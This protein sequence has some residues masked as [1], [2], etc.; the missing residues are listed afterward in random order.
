VITL[1]HRKEIIKEVNFNINELS[2]YEN[3]REGTIRLLDQTLSLGSAS[4]STY[5]NAFQRMNEMRYICN[6]GAKHCNQNMR[7]TKTEQ[8]QDEA[9]TNEHELDHLLDNS[10]E[11]CLICGTDI[12]EEQ[13]S[14]GDGSSATTLENDQLRL[15]T[16]CAQQRIRMS[17]PQLPASESEP[18]IMQ[19]GKSENEL[20]SKITAIVLY[21]QGIPPEDKWYVF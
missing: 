6:H 21:V 17:A 5:L 7:S 18:D 20:P 16:F 10:D 1:P 11:A 8:D 19:L 13:E 9:G 14:S 4:C 2:I 12:S 15:C 3:A